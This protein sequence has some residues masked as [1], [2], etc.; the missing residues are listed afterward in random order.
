MPERRRNSWFL[1]VAVEMCINPQQTAAPR[2]TR[3]AAPA[4]NP[5]RMITAQNNWKCLVAQG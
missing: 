1:G 3:N 4:A 2:K 5:N